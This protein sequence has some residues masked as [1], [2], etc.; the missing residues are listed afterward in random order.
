MNMVWSHA[1]LTRRRQLFRHPARLRS[2]S[3]IG[4]SRERSRQGKEAI[5]TSHPFPPASET[6][7]CLPTTNQRTSASKT[8]IPAS[9]PI[10]VLVHSGRVCRTWL[11][12]QGDQ[13]SR[14][15]L[16][17]LVQGG[18]SNLVHSY[19]VVSAA[20]EALSALHTRSFSPARETKVRVWLVHHRVFRPQCL[21]T[22]STQW[23]AAR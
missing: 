12:V 11:G 13:K 10:V 6:T 3:E 14:A 1:T 5:A 2:V 4:D 20:A 15:S 18:S 23:A 16:R 7:S 17:G 9:P 8:S 19:G 21:S 22:P